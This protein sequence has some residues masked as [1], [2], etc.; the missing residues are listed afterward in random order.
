[1]E[2]WFFEPPRE[3]EIGSKNREF[4]KSKVAQNHACSFYNNWENK[5][6]YHGTLVK[7]LAFIWMVTPYTHNKQHPQESQ[8]LWVAIQMKGTEEYFLGTV[9]CVI[10]G[11]CTLWVWDMWPFKWKLL[12]SDLRILC[13]FKKLKVNFLEISSMGGKNWFEKSGVSKNRGSK[14]RG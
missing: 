3:K 14:H 5:Q 6:K 9:Y 10:E 13:G 12:R 4:E 7:F 2:S 11:G 1:M 8:A